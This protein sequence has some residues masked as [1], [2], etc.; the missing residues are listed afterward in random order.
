MREDFVLHDD[1]QASLLA[2]AA[3]QGRVLVPISTCNRIEWYHWGTAESPDTPVST[4][5]PVARLTGRAAVRHLFAVSAGLESQL[6]GESE[7]LGQVRRAWTRARNAGATNLPVNLIFSQALSAGRRLRRDTWVG[8]HARSVTQ[9]GVRRVLQG[10]KEPRVLVLGAGEAVRS[11]LRELS[12]MKLRDVAIVCRR[13]EM[14]LPLVA[15][16]ASW[17][18][19]PWSRLAEECRRADIIIAATAARQPV[20]GPTLLDG[21]RCTLL[22][23]GVPRNV[24]PAVRHLAGVELLDLDDLRLE[25]CEPR[26]ELLQQAWQILDA[27]LDHL[28]DLL[29]ARSRAPRLAALHQEGA[30][31]ASEEAERVLR[32]LDQLDPSGEALVRQLAERVAK[33]VLF[34]AS[35]LIREV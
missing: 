16:R 1:D 25:G 2:R 17:S 33:R 24:D 19:A 29:K 21:R 31:I 30:R 18:L 34:P 11:T 9:A 8:R 35:R 27:E 32:E 7:I 22:D 20:I 14:A 3:A 28:G 5:A 15:D 23:L 4:R 6:V 13:P 26:A 12:A 10:R